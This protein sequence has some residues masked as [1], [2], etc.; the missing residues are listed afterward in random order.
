MDTEFLHKLESRLIRAKADREAIITCAKSEKRAALTGAESREFTDLS[1]TIEGLTERIEDIRGEIERSGHGPGGFFET[2]ALGRKGSRDSETFGRQWCSDVATR[3]HRMGGEQRSVISGSI[4][5]PVL[6]DLPPNLM[7]L[8]FPKRLID[9]FPNRRSIDSYTYEFP[10]QVSRTNNAAPVADLAQK[11]TSALTVEMVSGRAQIIAT[12]S[13]PCPIRVFWDMQ[14]VTD[15]LQMQLYGCVL[16]AVEHQVISGDGTGLNAT[17]ILHQVGT[18]VQ[19]YD[20]DLPTTLRSAVSQMQTLGEQPTGWALNPADAQAVD[21]L[22]WSTDGGF[23]SGGYENDPGARYGT[24]ANIFGSN[25]IQR[26]VTP[27]VPQGIAILGDFRELQLFLRHSMRLDI[28][29]TGG[30][31]D[32][33]QTNAFQMRAEIPVGVGILRPQ[34]F[35]ITYLTSGS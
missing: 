13:D 35:C 5:V 9:A 23:L 24:S 34:A 8:P 32:L 22:R 12:L 19:H 25:D 21:L 15:W 2:T 33:F 29:T 31:P 18:T 27:N 6:V 16:D 17:G 20:T 3:L 4:D 30:D 1:S 11:P 26:I 7:E 14:W 10:Q 28:A